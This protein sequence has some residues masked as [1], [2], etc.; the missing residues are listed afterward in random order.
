MPDQTPAG[1]PPPIIKADQTPPPSIPFYQSPQVL[2]AVAAIGGGTAAFCSAF[3]IVIPF[4]AIEI[5]A[6]LGGILAV[7]G[8]GFA[9][10]RRIRVGL[11]PQNEASKITLL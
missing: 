8:G 2:A 9:L 10:Y 7:L 1:E 11:D 6:G 3:H 5:S 4:S